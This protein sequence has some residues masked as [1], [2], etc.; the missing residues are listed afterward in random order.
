[1]PDAGFLVMWDRSCQA[2]KPWKVVFQGVSAFNSIVVDFYGCTGGIYRYFPRGR[3]QMEVWFRHAA[4]GTANMIV[5]G[6]DQLGK[7]VEGVMCKLDIAPHTS[8]AADLASNRS[9]D[10]WHHQTPL[11]AASS[12]S[13]WTNE[14][15]RSLGRGATVLPQR[16]KPPMADTWCQSDGPSA[17]GIHLNAPPGA[18]ASPHPPA[19]LA[20]TLRQQVEARLMKRFDKS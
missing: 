1:M 13:D 3:D 4:P 14:I 2:G 11:S 18:G 6:R 12:A 17:Y 9:N 16:G 20:D 7:T 15:E 5:F 10:D 8:S 19:D